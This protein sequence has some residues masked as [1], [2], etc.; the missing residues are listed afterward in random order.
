ML[1]SKQYADGSQL[2]RAKPSAYRK[3]QIGFWGKKEK[4]ECRKQTQ[5]HSA[6]GRPQGHRNIDGATRE[7]FYGGVHFE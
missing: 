3:R 5:S 6:I 1:K 4:E 7:N 2:K